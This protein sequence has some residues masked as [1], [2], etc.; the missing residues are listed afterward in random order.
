MSSTTFYFLLFHNLELFPQKHYWILKVAPLYNNGTFSLPP[1]KCKF[2]HLYFTHIFSAI[3]HIHKIMW[4]NVGLYDTSK[5]VAVYYISRKTLSYNNKAL[6]FI[7]IFYMTSSSWHN[8]FIQVEL[9]Y[10]TFLHFSF[11]F[12]LALTFFCVYIALGKFDLV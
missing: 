8:Y 9:F 2:K 1:L 12:Q 10:Y 3:S 11:P 5:F 6:K 7:T 4:P